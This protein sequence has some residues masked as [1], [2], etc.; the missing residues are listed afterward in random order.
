MQAQ[1]VL[2]ES[3]FSGAL[4]AFHGRRSGNKLFW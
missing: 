2:E 1:Q 3:P 4:F